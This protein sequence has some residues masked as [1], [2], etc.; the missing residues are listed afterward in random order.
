[1]ADTTTGPGGPDPDH[2][3]DGPEFAEP[4]PLSAW[5]RVAWIAGAVLLIVAAFYLMAHTSLP[6]INPAQTAP[7]GH[8]PGRCAVCHTV[9]ADVPVRAKT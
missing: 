3:G 8:Y 2:P 7:S 1:M 5:A 6:R 4:A 9:T